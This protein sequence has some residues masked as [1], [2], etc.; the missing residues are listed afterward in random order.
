MKKK[1][2][3]NMYATL[4]MFALIPLVVGGFIVS[5]YTAEVAKKEIR[6]VTYNYMYSMAESEGLGIEEMIES[7][8]Y[9][10]TMSIENLTDYCGDLG[11]LD[12]DSSYA[13]VADKNATMLWHPTESKI[14]EPVTNTVILGLCADMKA[15][16]NIPE[17]NGVVSYDF[18]GA[19]K[20]A[21]Y[22]V[23]EDN[24]FVLVFSA[25]ESDVLKNVHKMTNHTVIVDILLVIIFGIASIFVAR[26][27]STPLTKIAKA[28]EVLASGD[29]GNADVDVTA[30]IRE[31]VSII[32]ATAALKNAL[33]DSIGTVKSSAG[34]LDNAVVDVDEKT[35]NNV[36]S[37]SQISEAINEVAE[38]SQAVAEN[39]QTMALKAQTLGDS[40]DRL[41]EN[42]TRLEEA[43]HE[44]GKANE[45]ASR[46]METVMSSSDESVRAVDDITAKVSDT[47]TAVANISACVQMIE[48]ISTQTNLLSL[49]ASIEAARAGEA[50]RGFAVV[51]EEIRKLADDS[52]KSAQ[53]IKEIVESVTQLS[54]ETV[55]VAGRVAEIIAKEQEFISETQGKFTILSSSVDVSTHEITAIG[56]MTQE[57]NGIKAD[58]TN[59]TSELGAISEELGASAQEVS[60]SC[61][62][63]T[64]A[65]TDTQG[66]TEEMR[67]INE[68]LVDAVNFFKL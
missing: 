13:Y 39:A 1:T 12:V 8:G 25:D 59:A 50:G 11:I 53:E 19:Q 15:G 37:V 16:K 45:E 36:E 20:Y 23:A 6:Q 42:V 4:V 52:G 40:V 29:I 34:E 58:L 66:R 18:K 46:Y 51:A 30:H 61:T 68:N 56:K 62:T 47:N 54:N 63:V 43:A 27:I 2:K 41:S 9:E 10:E 14:G 38:T 35:A 48:D 28:T 57:L 64:E 26:F 31:T 65:C 49:N 60:A 32:D 55:E 5:M 44:I 24:S 17:K 33:T 21:S 22:H 3:L 7:K 67:A